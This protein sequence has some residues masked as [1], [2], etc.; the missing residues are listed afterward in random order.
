MRPLFKRAEGH[1]SCKPEERKH[2][3][4]AMF[5]SAVASFKGFLLLFFLV[6]GKKP[7]VHN[8][9][10]KFCRG[11]PC[12]WLRGRGHSCSFSQDLETFNYYAK[13]RER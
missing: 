11:S 5:I 8:F 9:S 2:N 12:K 13:I 10:A 1:N 3:R 6:K 4:E 7:F